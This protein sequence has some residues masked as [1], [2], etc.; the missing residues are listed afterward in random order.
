[1]QLGITLGMRTKKPSKKTD[2]NFARIHQS[3]RVTP[4]MEAGVAGHVWSLDEIIDLL[5]FCS[6]EILFRCDHDE[7]FQIVHV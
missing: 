3:L 7:K 6:E 4:A 1:M 2:Y 5:I